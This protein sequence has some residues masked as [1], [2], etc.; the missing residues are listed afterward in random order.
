[1][2]EKLC[3]FEELGPAETKRP[4][5]A[6]QEA[7]ADGGADGAWHNAQERRRLG[8]SVD[9]VWQDFAFL[10][11]R[12]ECRLGGDCIHLSFYKEITTR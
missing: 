3:Q 4:A 9:R 10:L 11:E 5:L 6:F 12:D 7:A 2:R 8:R 1:M